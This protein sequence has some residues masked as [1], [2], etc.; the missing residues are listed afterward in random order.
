[1]ELNRRISSRNLGLGRSIPDPV[2]GV[3]RLHL[4]N[5]SLAFLGV[6]NQIIAAGR[7][8]PIRHSSS[9]VLGLQ[10]TSEITDGTTQ[11]ILIYSIPKIAFHILYTMKI[12]LQASICA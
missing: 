7:K 9:P 3:D 5:A 10:E 12:G 6:H 11:D 8:I 4:R 2:S 1:M